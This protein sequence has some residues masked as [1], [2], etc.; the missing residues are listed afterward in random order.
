[1]P[2]KL[3]APGKRKG[4]RYYLI[5]GKPTVGPIRN[6]I[7]ISTRTTN[8][9]IAA[10]RK[11]E[12]IPDED[13]KFRTAATLYAAVNP[14]ARG[15]T[16]RYLNRINETALGATDVRTIK[17]AHVDA[18]ALD[19]Y[20]LD[21]YTNATRD[22][23]VYTPIISVLAYAA[24]NEWCGLRRIK[25]PELREQETR[26]AASHVAPRLLTVTTGYKRLLILWLF[27]HGTRITDA[28]RN[29]R[30]TSEN[31]ESRINLGALTYDQF[32]SKNGRWKTF[33]LDIEVAESLAQ[34][35]KA[36]RHGRLFKQWSHRASVYAWLTPLCVEQGVKFTPHMARH[37]V[38]KFFGNNGAGIR[39]VMDR[40]GQD[41]VN[42]AK[43]YMSADIEAVRSV[44]G[45][46]GRLAI[47]GIR[48]GKRA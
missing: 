4:N 26:A 13:V 38:G 18:C 28:L 27:K 39:A 16:E 24:A 36:D 15:D 37:S 10:L 33:P 30:W 31:G 34:I 22:R 3:I 14:G 6:R 7:E 17:Q 32:I 21:K 42:A 20:P 41:S 8:P 47:G 23:N 40:L 5:R 12:V 35:P 19:L 29:V 11:I 45:K 46:M 48:R 2:L 1:M 25:R 9:A 44:Q 43:R